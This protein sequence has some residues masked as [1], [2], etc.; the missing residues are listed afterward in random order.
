MSS[1]NNNPL[2]SIGSKNK[3]P[4]E[5]SRSP[6]P[7]VDK[8][9]L[10]ALLGGSFGLLF[11]GFKVWMMRSGYAPIDNSYLRLRE[12]HVLVLFYIF[13][14]ISINGFI[15]QAAPRLLQITKPFSL[16]LS[17]LI[18]L[19]PIAGVALEIISGRTLLSQLLLA[20]PPFLTSS[21]L[22]M[23]QGRRCLRPHSLF[24]IF[25]LLSMS[26]GAFF[27]ISQQQLA[28][29]LFWASIGGA[30]LGTSPVFIVNLLGGKPLSS[31]LFY[32]LFFTFIVSVFLLVFIETFELGATLSLIV[33]FIF[34]YATRLFS[35]GNGTKFLTYAFRFG[36]FWCVIGWIILVLNPSRTD[37]T[38]HIL[39]IGWAMSILFALSL[40]IT[41]FIAGKGPINC[42]FALSAL[43]LWQ[44]APITR[45][46]LPQTPALLV[47]T[48]LCASVLLFTV[49]LTYILTFNWYILNKRYDKPHHK[50]CTSST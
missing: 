10:V 49:W 17:I 13:F 29:P 45:G 22:V 11:L 20:A 41:S 24:V 6:T 27:E 33:T 30:L 5:P 48:T 21:L 50:I 7:L 12:L 25:S 18:L 28:L 32:S 37:N 40:H 39:A 43:V 26:A 9:F 36:F 31:E 38:I 19:S 23:R 42:R 3:K 8:F 35:Q 1:T 34:C 47:L 16:A 15:I 44:I 46:I 4:S 2:Y 14:G